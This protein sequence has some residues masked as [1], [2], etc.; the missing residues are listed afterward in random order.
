MTPGRS[1]GKLDE[2]IRPTSGPEVEYAAH[3]VDQLGI[4]RMAGST[5]SS[6]FEAS[7]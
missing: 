7:A 4:K 5:P 6:S 3:V 2:H 1:F